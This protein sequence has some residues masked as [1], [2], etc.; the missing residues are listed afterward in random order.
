MKDKLITLIKYPAFLFLLPFFFVLHGFTENYDFVSVSDAAVLTATYL[1]AS[2]ILFGLFWLL[3]KNRFK[4][5]FLAFLIMAFH[6]FFG[7][8]YDSLKR[9]NQNA[10]FTKYSLLLPGAFIFFI[11]IAIYIKRKKQLSSKI[12][13]YLNILL[14]LLLLIDSISLISRHM[15]LVKERKI[16]VPE[17]FAPLTIS[18]K[19]DI[20]FIILDEY[21]GEKQLK[22][23]LGFDNSAFL[24]E[25]RSSGF[26]VINNSTSNYIST[27]VSVASL[28]TMNYPDLKREDEQQDKVLH[29]YYY[30]RESPLIKFLR[31]QQ[32]ELYNYSIFDLPGQKTPAKP[33]FLPTGTTLITSQTFLTRVK[34]NIGYHI[35]TTLGFTPDTLKGLLTDLQNNND[36]YDRTFRL[37]SEKKQKP[38][39]VYT[40]LMMPHYP[41]Y[42]TKEGKQRPDKELSVANKTNAAHY[43]EYLAFCNEK[44]KLLTSNIITHSPDAVIVLTGDHGFRSFDDKSYLPYS[45]YN[46][47]AVRLPSRDYS[48]FYDKLS[49]V[50]LFRTILN[51]EFNQHLPLLK[52]S[53]L[54]AY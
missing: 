47:C 53:C 5:A 18:S 9:I 38:K 3:Y 36:I 4:A 2:L 33:T 21:A 10:F 51:T 12:S 7:S 37:A 14:I 28:V 41:Y 35:Y 22:E 45:F 25:L 13:L 19:P 8:V 1:I 31:S 26:Y 24:Q 30:I 32:Y 52:D 20:Y 15:A 49:S 44:I 27:P 16:L 48:K 46:L 42:F 29:S 43:L 11:I 39:F 6:F 23:Q 17:G 40:H 50:N 34:D 54:M